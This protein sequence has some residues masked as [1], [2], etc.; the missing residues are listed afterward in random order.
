LELVLSSA[1]YLEPKEIQLL[2]IFMG[3]YDYPWRLEKQ[4]AL[5]N[6]RNAAK[7]KQALVNGTSEKAQDAGQV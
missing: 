1:S 7:K 5:I 4:I 2:E 6:A 3:T